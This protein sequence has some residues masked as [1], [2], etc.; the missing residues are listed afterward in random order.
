MDS[1]ATPIMPTK[2]PDAPPSTPARPP[3]RLHPQ[4]GRAGN[5]AVNIAL[6]SNGAAAHLASASASTSGL[7]AVNELVPSWVQHVFDDASGAQLKE[8]H[9]RGRRLI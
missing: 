2:G 6:T 9:R 5:P 7:S 1:S 8:P 4:T 3:P